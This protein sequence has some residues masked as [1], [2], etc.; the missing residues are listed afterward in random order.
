MQPNTF[1]RLEYKGRIYVQNIRRNR[2]QLR[3][4]I[5]IRKKSFR[6]TTLGR[7]RLV[8][9]WYVGRR[10]G[11]HVMDRGCGLLVWSHVT[12]RG[13]CTYVTLV[14]RLVDVIVLMR[15]VQV[16][17]FMWSVV[18]GYWCDRWDFVVWVFTWQWYIKNCFLA[19]PHRMHSTQI[20]N[21]IRW[22]L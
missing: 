5:W 8:L 16:V 1:T 17:V 11:S 18:H 2:I 13:D 9:M 10:C 20:N 4:M 3:S 22:P 6:I 12:G 7:E 21:A 15:Q 14:L 19:R